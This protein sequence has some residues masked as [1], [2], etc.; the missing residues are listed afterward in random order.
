MANLKG[1]SKGEEPTNIKSLLTHTNNNDTIDVLLFDYICLLDKFIFV[2][3]I[4]D[5]PAPVSVKTIQQ[6]SLLRLP[7]LHLQTSLE[8]RRVS[9]NDPFEMIREITEL[10][11]PSY[12]FAYISSDR[13]YRW[14]F[15][16]I[17]GSQTDNGNF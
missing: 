1:R 17:R 11:K 10:I 16:S 9:T 15:I 14:A 6:L 2:N 5:F 4:N 3:I 13:S 12:K 8:D 7:Y